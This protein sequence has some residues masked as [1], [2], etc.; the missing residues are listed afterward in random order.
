MLEDASSIPGASIRLPTHLN[1]IAPAIRRSSLGNKSRQS[2][3]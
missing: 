3:L 2:N 1:A